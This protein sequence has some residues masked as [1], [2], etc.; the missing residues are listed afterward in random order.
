MIE[1]N[2]NTEE[3]PLDA[4]LEKFAIPYSP[5]KFTREE[6]KYLKPFFTNV[7]KPIYASHN[8]PEEVTGALS[9]RYS[10]ATK[11]LRRMFI[12][13]YIKA[14]VEPESQK[15]WEKMKWSQKKRS[16]RTRDNFKEWIDHMNQTGGI[17]DV[18][19]VQ[20]GR[21]FFGKWLAEYGDDSIAEMGGVHLFIE[22][23]SNIAVNEIESKRIGLSPLEKSSRYVQFWEKRKDGQFQYVI[24]G[25]LK[26]TPEEELFKDAM[27]RLFET[28]KGISDGYKEYIRETYPKA[29]DE[30]ERP[31]DRAISAKRF[32]DIR[33]LLPFSTQTSVALHGN[34]R[35]FEDLIN[36]MA[37]H[38]IGEVRWVGQ[39]MHRELSKIVPSFVTRP[40][41]ERG[42]E[43]QLYRT[44]M[45]V[46]R[47]ELAGKLKEKKKN[48]NSRWVKLDRFT[49]DPELEVLS[50][51]LFKA[52]TSLT[53]EEIKKQVSNWNEKKIKKAFDA[54]FAERNFGKDDPPRQEVRFR[55]VPRA[56]ENAEFVYDV[57]GRAGDFRDL[58]RHRQM[59][60]ERQKF[61]TKWGY[62]LEDEVINSPFKEQI[63]SAL[64]NAA[65]A[66]KA[67]SEKNPWVAQ[68]LIP[69]AYLQHWYINA[70]AREIYWISE[71]R[72]GPQGREHYRQICQDIA[73]QAIDAAPNLFSGIKID[74]DSHPI[75]RRESE[76]KIE[77]KLK[78]LNS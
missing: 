13:E 28:Y 64:E 24:P 63:T 78:E 4:N 60:Q 5:E 19:N 61:T 48:R 37:A 10:R 72:T 51:F 65:D 35:A 36:R 47:E 32:D 2:Y 11:S 25:E 67:I 42:A 27:D 75:S 50:A 16:L 49:K 62:D 57:W 41:S 38:P 76:K 31:Y 17:D 40:A 43:M 56:F 54:I 74:W 34:G 44:N 71:L 33:D 1:R 14:I 18:V 20:R 12:D 15:D 55:K 8:L 53:L 73:R 58:H 22:G 29:E 68:Y 46:L 39:Q 21:D 70:T 23:A 9:S 3:L 77:K 45:E 6:K 7:D 52:S 66:F 59:T 69:F 26:G 30:E